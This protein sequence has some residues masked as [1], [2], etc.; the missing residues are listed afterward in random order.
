[1]DASLWGAGVAGGRTCCAGG[2]RPVPAP[3]AAA[4]RAGRR[5]RAPATLVQGNTQS[6]GFQYKVYE[7][8]PLQDFAIDARVLASERYHSGRE[9]DL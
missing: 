9:S 1:M 6:T 3:S 4:G 2:L 8:Q 7:L 5:R